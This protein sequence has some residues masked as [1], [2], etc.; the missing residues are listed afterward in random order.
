MKNAISQALGLLFTYTDDKACPYISF[1]LRL[2][3]V[4]L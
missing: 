2:L 1:V 4:Q 3:P